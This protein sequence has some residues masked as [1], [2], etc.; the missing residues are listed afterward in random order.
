MTQICCEFVTQIMIFLRK[1]QGRGHWGLKQCTLTIGLSMSFY[2]DFILILF[3]IYPDVIQILSKFSP[4][5]IQILSR[6]YPNFGKNLAK[7]W[8]EFE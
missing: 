5:F 2:A 4:D 7:I 1:N 8:I 3:R 6:F